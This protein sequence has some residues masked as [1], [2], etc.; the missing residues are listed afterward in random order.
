MNLGRLE[1]EQIIR[2]PLPEVFEFFSRAEN[3]E[4]IT[5]PWLRFRLLSRGR[6]EMH[7]GALIDYRLRLH[8]IPIRWTSLIEDWEHD[9]RF[10]DQQVRGPYKFWRHEHVFSEVDGGTRVQDRVNYALPL[11]RLGELAGLPLV[12]RDVTRI[13]DYRRGAV[14]RLL[15]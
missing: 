13:F 7:P 2:R 3:L 12:R 15:G 14:E 11:G 6:V 10:V 4:R 1:R 5:P 9:Q 8:G